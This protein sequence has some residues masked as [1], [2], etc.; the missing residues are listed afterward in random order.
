MRKSSVDRLLAGTMLALISATPTMSI[1]APDRL[2]SAMPLPPQING[3]APRHRDAAPLPPPPT[4][5]T[6]PS[7]IVQ[8]PRAQEPR[9]QAPAPAQEPEASYAATDKQLAANDAQI[10]NSL[11]DMIAGKM[12]ERRVER[13]PERKAIETY[14]AAHGNAPIWIRDGM[15]TAQAKSVIARF[16]N[17]AADGLDATDYSVPDFGALSSAEA[18][19]DGDIKLTNSV[20]TYARHL[21]AGRIA[22]TRVSAEVDYGNHTPEPADILRKVAD[23]RDIDASLDSFNPPHDG[24]KA[25]KSKLAELRANASAPRAEVDDRIPDG[26]RINPGDKDA[27][28]PA[29]RQRLGVKSKTDDLVYDKALFNAITNVQA[30]ADIKP[31]GV[32]D[33]KTLNAVNGP[34][35]VPPT[36]QVERVIANMERWRWLPRDLGKTY[37]M[38]NIPDFTLKVMSN[39]AMVWTTRIV[40]GQP[41]SKATPLLTETMKYITVNPTW[42]VPPSIINNEYLPALQQDP[43]VL[44]RM[45]LKLEHN[46]DGSVHIFQ[47]PG[48]RNALGRIRFNFP[49][50]FLVYQ[51]DTPDK[52]LFAK[53]SRAFSHGCMRVQNPDKYA[54]VLLSLANPKDGYTVD[55]I[56]KMYGTGEVDIH[57]QT[58][59]PV[60]ITYQT[61]YVDDAGKL[62]IREDVYGRDARYYAL[63]KGD[64]R[65]IADMG[66]EGRGDGGGTAVRPARLLNNSYASNNGGGGSLF[67]WLF[68]GGSAAATPQRAP[69]RRTR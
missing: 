3:Q 10:T 66:I 40:T 24:F 51:H 48:E 37:V 60:H 26:H 69:A 30:R 53:D 38:V 18:L 22:P 32:I 49:N 39:G 20:L 50:K 54:E 17:A 1:A 55:R 42:N 28:V 16:K 5:Y 47:P 27:R 68:G 2:E 25:L 46:R 36:Q 33:S 45:G 7:A 61:A 62:V 6:P 4:G 35:P 29:L 34:K 59:I 15:L 31:T 65:K 67:G 57:L 11:R 14:Y 21:A 13:A 56:H 9:A 12:L 19:A 52:H 41:G 58:P 23:A 8:E 43:T 63:M 44:E 64:E